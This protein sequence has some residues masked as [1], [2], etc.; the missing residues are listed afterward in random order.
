MAVI[1]FLE[2]FKNACDDNGLSEGAALFLFQY[3][4]LDHAKK[5]VRLF[6]RTNANNK[7]HY[8]YSGIVLF[9]L[10]SY[11]PEEEVHS[12]GRNIFLHQQ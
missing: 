7:D 10:T 2:E 3:F 4:L 1:K 6:L 12:E 5:S 8:S 11:A 9:L